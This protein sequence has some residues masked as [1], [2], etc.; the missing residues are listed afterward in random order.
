MFA[1]NLPM[2]LPIL[3]KLPQN[4]REIAPTHF[5]FENMPISSLPK[6]IPYFLDPISCLSGRVGK[7]MWLL[8]LSCIQKR[9]SPKMPLSDTSKTDEL[10]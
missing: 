5:A 8:T 2:K 9:R 10:F 3:G 1:L 6:P 4:Y 7:V